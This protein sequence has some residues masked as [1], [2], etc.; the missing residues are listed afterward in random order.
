MM[1][2]SHGG[3]AAVA[4]W[5]CL[6]VVCFVIACCCGASMDAPKHNCTLKTHRITKNNAI[7]TQITRQIFAKLESRQSL[8]NFKGIL[9]EADGI[10]ISRCVAFALCRCVVAVRVESEMHCMDAVTDEGV[11]SGEEG[12]LIHRH[13]NIINSRARTRTTVIIIII[14]ISLSLTHTP[15]HTEATWGST[16]CLKRWRSFKRR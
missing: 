1:M 9:N 3:A 16:A 4:G 15:T 5:R 12:D 7:L 13:I 2:H 8:L 10:V 14:I 11:V 6:V